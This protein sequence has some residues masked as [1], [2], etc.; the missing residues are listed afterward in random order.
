[1]AK[2]LLISLGSRGDMEPFLALG[3]E[4]L[5]EGHEIGCCMPA[6]FE[7]LVKE[8]TP[9]FF[10]QNHSFL[11]LV[12]GQEISKIMGQVGSGFSRLLIL[13]KLWRKI[14]PIQEQLIEDQQKAVEI[15]KPDQIIFHIKCIYPVIWAI[16]FEGSVKL[17]SPIPA[18]LDPIIDIPHIGFGK[19]RWKAWNLFTYKL[20]EYALIHQ[21]ILGYGK[22]FLKKN[23][24]QLNSTA[25]KKFYRNELAVEYAVSPLLFSR[26][27][28][29]PER[30][31]VT[32][33]RMRKI[34]AKS[35][36]NTDLEH[37]LK[38][39]PNP[40]YI[41]F[42]S[43]INA[44]PHQVALDI[45]A[46]CEE[47]K[48]SVIINE[49]WGGIQCPD[50]LPSW[51]L[52]IKDI[53]FDYLFPKVKMVIHHGGSGTTHSAL[54]FKKPQAIIPHIADQFFWNKQIEKRGVGCAGFKIKK[55]NQERLKNLIIKLQNF[56]F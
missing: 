46:V 26:P 15:F 32:S 3:E 25:L 56:Q 50:R 33:F 44:Q 22:A 47:L 38:S 8:L 12:E 19:S 10:P 30:A 7:P 54:R 5:A 45:L 11:E 55:W 53:P 28:Y 27:T 16:K 39:N 14:K 41:G 48:L 36:Q 40:L 13:F 29:W 21:S 6:Q 18:L 42:G 51:A 52:K 49:S 2:I 17:L 37:F 23:K 43:M 34:K 20:A 31:K 9:K 35:I 24:L 1:M 4:V